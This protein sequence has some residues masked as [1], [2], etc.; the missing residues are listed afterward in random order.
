MLVPFGSCELFLLITAP[1]KTLKTNVRD[2]AWEEMKAFLK[3]QSAPQ[4]LEG[5]F[6]KSS[7][8]A[9]ARA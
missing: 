7:L 3:A 9:R 1:L 6:S 4:L 2:W 5:N 8:A